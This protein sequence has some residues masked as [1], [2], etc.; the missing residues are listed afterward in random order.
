MGNRDSHNIIYEILELMIQNNPTKQNDI[1]YKTFISYPTLERYKKYLIEKGFITSGREYYQDKERILW[2]L[3]E[4]GREL[5][6]KMKELEEF[7]K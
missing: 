2:R 1:M 4:K 7:L 5:Y 6:Q 3:T